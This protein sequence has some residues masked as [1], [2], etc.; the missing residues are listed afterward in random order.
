MHMTDE[1]DSRPAVELRLHGYPA[2]H[3][4][5]RPVTLT[6]KHGLALLARL[7]DTRGRLARSAAA[8]LLWPDADGTLAR[9]RLRRLLHELN[10]RCG[11]PLVGG[12]ADT[13]WLEGDTVRL[14]CDWTQ[15][16]RVACSALRG[17]P[18]GAEQA[19]PLLHRNAHRVLDGFALASD[20]FDDWLDDTRREHA[21]LVAR[22]L[23]RLALRW[24]DDGDPAAAATAAERVIQ[25][26]PCTEPAHASLIAAR[27]ALGDAAGVESAYIECADTL[28]RE[29]GIRPSTALERAYA[30]A[31]ARAAA[32]AA[33]TC[34]ALLARVM[35]PHGCEPTRHASVP[36][37][38]PHRMPLPTLP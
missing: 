19:A 31:V 29:L 36:A 15:A 26:D 1:P 17:E 16:R 24:L 35:S 37:A 22:A 33:H 25:L 2:L 9:T 6:L 18:V 34:S 13:L 38:M 14:Q 23:Q 28:R 20:A 32:P 12:D 5:A 4:G 10:R 21:A 3:V 8:T 11:V 27:A 30:D 7:A